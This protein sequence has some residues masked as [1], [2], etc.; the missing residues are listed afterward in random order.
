MA[1]M[2]VFAM[3][4]CIRCG[5]KRQAVQIPCGGRKIILYSSCLELLFVVRLFYSTVTLLARF[6]GLSTLRPR[7]TER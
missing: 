2:L 5:N 4:A 3:H 1:F 7:A 6:L